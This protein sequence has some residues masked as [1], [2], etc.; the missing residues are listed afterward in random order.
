MYCIIITDKVDMALWQI[1]EYQQS[2]RTM[3]TWSHVK[4]HKHDVTIRRI[5]EH[6]NLLRC[7]ANK[8]L[9]ANDAVADQVT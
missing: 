4:H 3:S 2:E 8:N 7:Y 1:T 9:L 6:M 5:T